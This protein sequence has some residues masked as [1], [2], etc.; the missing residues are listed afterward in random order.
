MERPKSCRMTGQATPWTASGSPRLTNA[1]NVSRVRKIDCRVRVVID[2]CQKDR[3]RGKWKALAFSR[4]GVSVPVCHGVP[5]T[6]VGGCCHHDL[7]QWHALNKI[8]R[9]WA[10]ERRLV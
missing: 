3:G 10:R 4:E 8:A 2:S 7:Q 5:E 6:V 1:M 9:A